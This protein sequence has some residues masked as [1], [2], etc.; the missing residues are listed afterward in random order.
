MIVG[1][2]AGMG[3]GMGMMGNSGQIIN[4][5]FMYAGNSIGFT[6]RLETL[7]L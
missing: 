5:V 6:T 3:M 2:G 7:T 4:G 1:G